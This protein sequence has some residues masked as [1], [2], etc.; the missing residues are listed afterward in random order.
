MILDNRNNVDYFMNKAVDALIFSY[1]Y[2]YIFDKIKQ[3]FVIDKEGLLFCVCN[4]LKS[5]HDIMDEEMKRN[6]YNIVSYYRYQYKNL[7]E[8]I[9]VFE[10][11]NKIVSCANSSTRSKTEEF[12]KI[13]LKA[14]GFSKSSIHNATRDKVLYD[15]FKDVKDFIVSDFNILCLHTELCSEQD[16]KDA[17]PDLIDI[18]LPCMYSFNLLL[19]ENPK[20]LL[21]EEFKKRFLL[22]C[23]LLEKNIIENGTSSDI[24]YN[25]L[26]KEYNSYQKK[27]LKLIE[28]I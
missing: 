3:I 28:S 21:D 13:Q 10:L 19:D 16:Y 20:L 15:A 17:I 9:E 12:V 23:V 7:E 4:K 27:V 8:N 11:C 22:T 2:N 6:L 14:R 25:L 5:I 18:Q 1:D 24:P 26:K